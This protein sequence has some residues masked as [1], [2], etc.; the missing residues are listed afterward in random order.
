MPLVIT[1]P[2]AAPPTTRA[3]PTTGWIP[4]QSI[5]V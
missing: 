5:R 4:E 2:T 1:D 3:S